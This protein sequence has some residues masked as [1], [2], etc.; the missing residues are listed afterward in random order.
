MPAFL[1]LAVV[2]DALRTA[3]A[4]CRDAA[5]AF[6]DREV[7]AD[8]ST[9]LL[10]QAIRGEAPVK[11]GVLR[12][13]ITVRTVAPGARGVYAV[14]YA[15]YVTRGTAPHVILPRTK[16]ALHWGGD[17]GPTVA[18]VQHPGTKP[19]DFVRR[20]LGDATPA[21]RALMTEDGLALFRLMGVR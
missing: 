21:V 11:T 3:A 9:A 13:S 8:G 12:A 15:S 6:L 18:K 16:R 1:S 5:D 19:N 4:A 14:G 17:G 2:T 10:A 7:L 20:G